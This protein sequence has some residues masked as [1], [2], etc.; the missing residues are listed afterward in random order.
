MINIAF[1]FY[2]ISHLVQNQKKCLK[3]VFFIKLFLKRK[4]WVKNLLHEKYFHVVMTK[5][6]KWKIEFNVKILSRFNNKSHKIKICGDSYDKLHFI[7]LLFLKNWIIIII[8]LNFIM[9]GN[10]VDN[11]IKDEISERK[12]Q[13]KFLFLVR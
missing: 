6:Q 8:I 3:N 9:A 10:D 1:S 7:F 2:V 11:N 13:K 4:K 12:L 5:S